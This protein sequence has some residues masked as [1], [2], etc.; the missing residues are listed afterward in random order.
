MQ[1]MSLT[2][3]RSSANEQRTLLERRKSRRILR[4]AQDD[5]SSYTSRS[6][7]DSFKTI[8]ETVSFEFDEE[9]MGSRTYRAVSR[10]RNRRQRQTWDPIIHGMS[11]PEHELGWEAAESTNNPDESSSSSAKNEMALLPKKGRY[12]NFLKPSKQATGTYSNRKRRRL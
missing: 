12:F 11:S 5:A 8:R 2:T 10:D 4:R 1:N 3:S 6:T 9:L 7:G